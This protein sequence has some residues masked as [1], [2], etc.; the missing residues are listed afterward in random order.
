MNWVQMAVVD[1]EVKQ[2][3]PRANSLPEPP[4]AQERKMLDKL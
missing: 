1:S 3:L 2:G 4:E